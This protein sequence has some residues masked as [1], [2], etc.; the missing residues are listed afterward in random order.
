MR[1]HET[2]EQTQQRRQQN[3][4]YVA[5]QR[6]VET[7]EEAEVRRRNVAER[8]AQR[9]QIFN[10]NTW[11]IFEN[12]AIEY[13]ATLEYRSHRLIKIKRMDKECGFCG[14]LKWEEETPGMCCSGGRVAIPKLQ[15]PVQSLK[16]L[17]LC[18]SDESRQFLRNIRK[19]NSCFHMTSFG[20]D[21]IV[22]MPGFS[23]TFTIQGQVYHRIGSLLPEPNAK[24]QFLQIYF[25]GNEEAETERRVSIVPGVDRNTLQKIQRILKENN[26][27]IK[28]FKTAIENM[29]D[30]SC[31][32]VIHPD[33]VP[34]GQHERRY[35]APTTND[36]AAIVAGNEHTTCRDIVLR[37]RNNTL[38]RVA[39]TNRFYDALQY[40]IIFWNGQEGYHFEIP[41]VNPQNGLPVPNKKVSSMDFYAFHI[42]TRREDF[43]LLLRCRRL[44]QQF[45]VDMYVKIESERLRYIALNQSKLRA[46]NYVHLQDAVRNDENVNPNNLGQMV[47][48]PSTFVNSP[49]YLHMY[50]QDAFAYVRT[51]GRPDL[52]ITLTCNPNWEEIVNELLPGQSATDRHELIARVFRIKVKKLIHLLTKGK[53]FGVTQCYMY[54]IE[55]QKRGLPHVHVLLWL[56][57]KLR[58][59]Q[60]DD[61]ISAEI[62]DPYKDKML[63]DIVIKHMVHGPCGAHNMS[64]PCMKDGKCTKNYPRALLKD[65]QTNENGY[66]LYRRRAPQDG[67]RTAVI[68]RGGNDV[69]IDNSW[70]VPYNPLLL[71]IFD[72]HVNVEFCSSVQAIKY[73]CKYINKGSDQAIFNVRQ[74]GHINI[75]PRNEIE[76]FR[77]GRYVSSNEAVWRILGLPLH[78]RYP[79]VV[80]LAVHLPNGER[81]YFTE[82]NFNE[83]IAT[84]PKTTLAAFFHLCQNDDFA[85]TLLY[86]EVPRYY[87]WN[88]SRKEWKRRVQGT[89][90]EGWPGVKC[91]DA[92]GRIYTVHVSNFECYCLRMLLNVL[93]GPT[94]FENLRSVDE[95]TRATFRE[96]CEMRGLLEN[97][98][99]WN[100]TMDEA[101]LCRSAAKIRELFAILVCTCGLSNSLQMWEKYKDA[102]SEDIAHRLQGANNEL[103]INEALKI[104]E[105]KIISMS[106]KSL[107]DFGLPK[108]QYNG[109]LSTDVVKEL[110][111]DTKALQEY[112]DQMI[113]RLIPEQKQIF[114]TIL[115][116]VKKEEGG[117]FFLDAPGGTGKTFLLNLLLAEIRK[118][119]KIALAVASS[120]IA[121]TLLTGGRTAHSVFKLPL[122]LANEENPTCNISKSSNRGALLQQCKLIVWDEC[123]MSHKKAI[124]ALNLSLKDIRS[125]E[126]LMGGVVVLLAGDFRQTLPVIERGTPADEMNAC[127]KASPLWTQVEKLYLTCNMRVQLHNDQESG[128]HA[129]KLLQIGEGRLQ[130]DEE[131]K[132]TFTNEFCNPIQSEEQLIHKVFPNLH[133]NINNEEWLCERAILSPK[134]DSVN[135]INKK[136]LKGVIG[137]T[138]VYTS[139]DTVMASD[140]STT[141]PV[142]FL[143]S[144]ELSGVPSHRL[145]LKVGIPVLLMRNLDPPK[146]CNGTRLRITE[147]GRNVIKATIIT[148]ESK[149]DEVL[150]PRIPII[151]NNLPFQFKRLQFPLKASF[152]MTINK[153]Q[154]QTLKVAG[155]HLSTPCFS[156]GQLYV[157]CSRVSNAQNLHVLAED[158]KSYNIVYKSI[159]QL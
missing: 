40:P 135:K 96:A 59:N 144:L 18:E 84:P 54:S 95:Q 51:Y 104:I 98:N 130:T 68:K 26:T 20:A 10:R 113:P 79:T 109:E 149:G 80:H 152:S 37:T 156:H 153:S 30:Q 127:L 118:D 74:A 97:D 89:P 76:T 123:T 78:E 71:K 56:K 117:L 132:I 63:H 70:I 65:T 1:A 100:M 111:Y 5:T 145:E 16:E 11:G 128:E 103:I 50:T 124:E 133:S 73:I 38:S 154:G 146:L 90:V 82:Q 66:P 72:A 35:N 122:N 55:W 147:L 129:K 31:K 142:E 77:A 19:Y 24:P 39:D 143:N 21:S 107:T 112:I 108:P 61:I 4:A 139:I 136:I 106:G 27:L 23:P 58:P 60:V 44:L 2:P 115:Q 57:E 88:S 121:A 14:A 83:R 137:E 42:M 94:S 47:I 85:K 69:T 148:G 34:R 116:R 36:V 125:N 3:A 52:F 140:D 43:N 119:R 6:V 138:K 32:V 155:I 49:R 150:I 15:E 102:L 25:M 91:G 46:E 131:G 45:M 48:L 53:I 41:Q 29:P 81:I 33:R 86:S 28:E 134:N 13:D 159:L 99:H 75:D 87:T 92:L 93:R 9:R 151:P 7:T 67:G 17:Y 64:S 157:A 110:N 62:K 22:S 120:G 8:M 12:A 126:A 101:V 105:S 114:N 141:Y 158:N